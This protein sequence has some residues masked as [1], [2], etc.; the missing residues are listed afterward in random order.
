MKERDVLFVHGAW[1]GQWCWEKLTPLLPQYGIKALTLDL[2]GHGH[3]HHQPHVSMRDYVDAVV[4]VIREGGLVDLVLVGHSMG[5]VVISKVAEVLPERL[6]GLVYLAGFVLRDGESMLDNVP[7][8]TA[9][10]YR[11]LAEQHPERMITMPP[12]LARKY[13]FN[14]ASDEDAAWACARLQPQPFQPFADRI[15][16]RAFAGL[17]LPRH[18]LL[19]EQDK[20]LPRVY[21]EE[22]ARRLGCEPIR[23]DADHCPMISRPQQLASA[24]AR[25]C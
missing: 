16:M 14:E 19:G 7:Q 4:E 2:P 6:R 23:L 3:K 22:F 12:E 17:S 11:R 15:T 10:R 5:G 24:L 20:A 21:W 1:V 13:F 9:E 8:P 18:Y 25:L